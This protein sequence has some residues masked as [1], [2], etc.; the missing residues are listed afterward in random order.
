MNYALGIDYGKKMCGIARADL[1]SPVKVATPMDIVPTANIKDFINKHKNE[2][3]FVVLGASFDL[4]GKENEIQQDINE[5]K[6]YLES[7]GIK[8]FYQDERFSSKQSA[9]EEFYW[10]QKTKSRKQKSK[11]RLDARAA[12]IILQS[13]LDAKYF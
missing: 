10:S 3:G 4:S 5:F 8:V 12:T 2:I 1:T 6:K 13:F 7:Q 9:A 11:K